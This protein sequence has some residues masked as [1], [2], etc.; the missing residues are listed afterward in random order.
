MGSPMRLPGSR[1]IGG[2]VLR[3]VQH[4]SGKLLFSIRIYLPAEPQ[5]EQ[6]EDDIVTFDPKELVEVVK[7]TVDALKKE[8]GLLR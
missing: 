5:I 6:P 3:R 1:P 7:E 8:L 4:E 2:L